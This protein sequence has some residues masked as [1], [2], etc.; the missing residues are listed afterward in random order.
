[1]KKFE[2]KLQEEFNI[3]LKKEEFVQFQRSR[4]KWFVDGNPNTKYYHMKI[5]TM[6]RKNKIYM[7]KYENGQQVEDEEQLRNMVTDY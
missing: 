3:I 5:I 7:L 6:R 4:T 2:L 1:M